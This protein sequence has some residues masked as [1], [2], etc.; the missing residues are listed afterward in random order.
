MDPVAA[1]LVVIV[2]F[3][4]Y[5]SKSIPGSNGQKTKS[6][7]TEWHQTFP[8]FSVHVGMVRLCPSENTE[9]WKQFQSIMPYLYFVTLT[10]LTN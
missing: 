1:Q 3:R 2:N 6:L 5:D 10:I 4:V 9:S 7:C 8:E